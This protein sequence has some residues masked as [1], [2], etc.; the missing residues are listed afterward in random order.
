MHKTR[1]VR[2]V[3]PVGVTAV[4]TAAIEDAADD[5]RPEAGTV[6]KIKVADQT[7]QKAREKGVTT[8]VL[9]S[10]SQTL[11]YAARAREIREAGKKPAG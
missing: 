11:G 5:T 1:F 10:C 6:S 8:G 3:A 7:I 9:T 2:P 4:A